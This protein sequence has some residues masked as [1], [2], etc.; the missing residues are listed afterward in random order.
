MGQDD[1]RRRWQAVSA[2]LD[3]LL[4]LD[5][6]AARAT[7]L[8]R[9]REDDPALAAE[10]AELV[11]ASEAPDPLL[12]AERAVLGEALSPAPGAAAPPARIGPW[13]VTGVLGAGGMGAVYAAERQGEGF[14][15]RAAVK[16][17]AAGSPHGPLHERFLAE[18]GILARLE[19][20]GIAR[21]LD[22]G[23]AADGTPYLAMELVEG[24]TL[25]EACRTRRASVEERLAHFLDVCAAV[26]HAHRNLVVHRDLKPSNVM[27][28]REGRVKLLDFG[29]AKL[30]ETEECAAAAPTLLRAMTP[31]YAAP[32][33]AAGGATTPA[34]DV[35]ALGALLHELLAGVP[36]REAGGESPFTVERALAGATAAPLAR[37][38]RNDA[39]RPEG[40]RLARRLE[41][42]LER[43]VAHAMAREPERRYP[44]AGELAEDLRRHLDGRPVAARGGAAAYRLRRWAG[45]H[46]LAL[47]A[48]A[49]GLAV[50]VLV[51]VLVAQ[52]V[53]A[54]AAF[55]AATEKAGRPVVA[56]LS[57][58][59]LGTTEPWL[60]AALS[61][62]VA[63]ELGRSPGLAVLA[64][65]SVAGIGDDAELARLAGELGATHAVRGSVQTEGET[66]RLQATLVD[67]AS[68]RTLWAGHLDDESGARLATQAEL[69]RR[70]AWDLV[71]RL[72][73]GAGVERDET[74]ATRD[75]RA[76]EAY[77]RGLAELSG[78]TAAGVGPEQRLAAT[79]QF[80]LAVALD[81][82]FAEAWARLGTVYAKR[83]YHD[84]PSPDLEARSFA[85]VQ[86]AL[87]LDPE[88]AEA[89]L[90]RAQLNWTLPRGFDHQR[91]VA[92][93]RRAIALHPSLAEAHAELCKVYF[94]VGLTERALA[95]CDRALE[96]DPLDRTAL[97]R[98]VTVLADAG[99]DAEVAALLAERGDQLSPGIRAGMLIDVGRNDEALALLLGEGSGGRARDPE[100]GWPSP[101]RAAFERIWASI[102]LARLGRRAEAEALLARAEFTAETVAE[103][104]HLHHAYY[105][106]GAA[107]ALLGNRD[108]A[109]R[110]LTRA[111]DEGYPSYPRFANDG[112]LASLAS[113]PRFV[114]L[115]ARLERDWRRWGRE[116]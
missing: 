38:A 4:A 115:L 18:R 70:T 17:L 106:A 84:D 37:A 100:F 54:R 87:A 81:P 56:V 79:V 71:E 90:A 5:S 86:R 95:E 1:A 44:S 21:M 88:L 9:L 30:L 35:Y 34:T 104:S 93:L 114:A 109:L 29:I 24:E 41:G 116:L 10:L 107:H 23:V 113:E 73:A 97:G 45:R 49:L 65:A 32:E 59:P 22:A 52:R 77:L 69:A 8:A 94:H 112:D 101:S 15:Q 28:D 105:Y 20:P 36:P 19:H 103:E 96:L 27:V 31:Q 92:D 63:A 83:L 68:R 48:S 108:E 7:R 89:N 47:A 99:R 72:G 74:P 26:E 42:D 66:I 12:D 46:R 110:W 85:A 58:S 43:I 6:A 13:R 82:G 61:E 76:Y 53:T 40:E 55:P 16:V 51:G 39:S 60:A 62:G 75:P 78:R 98:K 67:L 102:A 14:V 91:A 111:A 50:V 64:S 33:Q 2:R 11:A 3:E 57:F 80:E 25:T